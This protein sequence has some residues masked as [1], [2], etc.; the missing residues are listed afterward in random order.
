MV[1]VRL[2]MGWNWNWY[3]YSKEGWPVHR[4]Q[5]YIDTLFQPTLNLIVKLPC[6]IINGWRIRVG[7]QYHNLIAHK[8]SVYSSQVDDKSLCECYLFP[9]SKDLSHL[10]VGFAPHQQFMGASCPSLL[11]V[12]S[13]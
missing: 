12:T 8:N 2:G 1:S 6:G 7:G 13:T 5:S 11:S 4:E 9:D 3:I 10:V